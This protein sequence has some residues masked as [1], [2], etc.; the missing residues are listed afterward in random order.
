MLTGHPASS[1][2]CGRPTRDARDFGCDGLATALS[3]L[4]M[5]ASS[6]SEAQ[7]VPQRSLANARSDVVYEAGIN[8]L[9]SAM[10]AGRAT[11][12]SLVDAY[13]ARIN[14]YDHVGPALNA[15]IRL[16][17]NARADAASRDAER[18]AGRVRGP[19]HGIPVILKDNYGT[20]DIPTT[21]GSI[22][23][24]GFVPS[25]DAFQVRKLREAGAVIL[26]KSNMHELAS[27]ITSISSMGAQTCNPYD[28]D[29]NPGG[30]SGGSGAAVAAS[31]AAIA[32]GSDTCGSIRIPSASNN[33]F[34]LRPTKGLSSIDGIIPLSHSQDVG[35]P[36]ART[37]TDL[38]IGLD[39]TIGADP[40]DTATR[41][42]EGRPLPRFVAS[43]DT[44]AL[45]GARFGVVT[46]YFGTEADDQEG[47]R[48][49]RAAMDKMKAR[50]AEFVDVSIADLDSLAT[51]AGV[52]DYE[53]KFDLIDYLARTPGA[54]VGALAE[55]LDRGLYNTALE[56]QLRRRETNGTR[57]SEA[58]R[59]ALKRRTEVR[60]GVVKFLEEHHLDA[61]VYPTVKRKPALMGEV[62]RGANCQLSAVTGLPALA[63]PAGFSPD[64]LPLGLELLGVPLGDARLVAFAYDYEQSAHPRRAPETTPPLVGARAPAPVTY[65]VGT[66]GNGVTAR[67]TFRFDPTRRT[68]DYAVHVSGIAPS[69]VYAVSLDRGTAEK[70]GPMLE[71]LSGPGAMEL[72]GTLK[73]TAS[74]RGDLIAGRMNLTIYTS[75]HPAGAARTPLAVRVVA[76]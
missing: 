63:M 26:G 44:G 33:L 27:G 9:Q 60:D 73:L 72:K 54:P 56:P 38:A 18:K 58:Y 22:A 14:A 75:D 5:F 28:P 65:T 34:G 16:N 62:Q 1:G 76:P 64:G 11:S 25:A 48:V 37:V 10:A 45:R 39:A 42:L 70:K 41:I 74:E 7:A 24:A 13:V 30:S 2:C 3:L 68:L 66:T 31:F 4:V 69:H 36:L 51:R 8:E 20:T 55:I 52:I 49:V 23:L 17:P 47:A 29:R 50:G 21:A 57:D 46:A 12:V 67:G 6:V 19:L 15:M 40:A 61:L 53:F 35:G 71:R 43:L 59:D 32:W